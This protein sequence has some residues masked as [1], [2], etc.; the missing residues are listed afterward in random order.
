[1]DCPAMID[2]R[3]ALLE[4]R[5]LDSEELKIIEPDKLL[6]FAKLNRIRKALEYAESEEETV[7]DTS[8]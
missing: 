5:E 7:V 2:S 1:M 4:A 3:L 6:D 8:S